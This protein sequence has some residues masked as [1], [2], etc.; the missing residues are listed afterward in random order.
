MPACWMGFRCCSKRP[1]SK[2]ATPTVVPRRLRFEVTERVDA[3][4][5]VVRPLDEADAK[6]AIDEAVSEG[7]EAL[8]VSLLQPG[9]NC[10]SARRSREHDLL[11]CEL[12]GTR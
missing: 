11:R 2:P 4:G 9:K 5:L 10:G 7:I 6:R 12:M 3:T 1:V 8:A